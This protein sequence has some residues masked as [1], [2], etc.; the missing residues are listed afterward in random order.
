[1]S[2][3]A[4]CQQSHLCWQKLKREVFI[5]SELWLK[6][7]TSFRKNKKKLTQLGK[8]TFWQDVQVLPIRIWSGLRVMTE[9]KPKC[10]FGTITEHQLAKTANPSSAFNVLPRQQWTVAWWAR[11]RH[12]LALWNKAA[13]GDT[14]GQTL[15]IYHEQRRGNA[16]FLWTSLHW[17][18]G[19]VPVHLRIWTW[20]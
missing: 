14:E 3:G 5:Q 18:W 1:M 7:N 9:R 8:T 13:M 11:W 2:V 16:I 19:L 20:F 17:F 12:I 4:G 15:N 10:P 6:L